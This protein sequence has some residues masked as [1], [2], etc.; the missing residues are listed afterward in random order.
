M[1]AINSPNSVVTGN[2]GVRNSIGISSLVVDLLSRQSVIGWLTKQQGVQ[3]FAQ[4]LSVSLNCYALLQ[5]S[6]GVRQE[7][8]LYSDVSR[9]LGQSIRSSFT[10]HA[11]RGSGIW[12]ERLY[13]CPYSIG[14]V[15]EHFC[16]GTTV[17][18][19][20]LQWSWGISAQTLGSTLCVFKRT[21]PSRVRTW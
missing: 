21:I 9:F 2:I 20:S 10:R 13:N 17:F 8:A 16:Q 14:Q 11:D 19:V 6:A 1:R 3:E 12:G 4:Q 15:V 5:T 7:T 18:R